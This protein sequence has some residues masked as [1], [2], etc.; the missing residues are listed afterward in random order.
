MQI[1]AN[2]IIH[3]TGFDPHSISGA[4]SIIRKR[5]LRSPAAC[6]ETRE[7]MA[8]WGKGQAVHLDDDRINS[9]RSRV[10]EV[11]ISRLSYKADLLTDLC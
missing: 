7:R 4:T 10:A 1:Y 11:N 9:T 8:R 6:S 2:V 3:L 5:R